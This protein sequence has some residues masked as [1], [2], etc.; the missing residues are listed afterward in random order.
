M[1]KAIIWI[2]LRNA[3]KGSC[4]A[5]ERSKTWRRNS[6]LGN[7]VRTISMINSLRQ[8]RSS[9]TSDSRRRPSIYSTRGCR[10]GSQILSSTSLP[11]PSI[12]RYSSRT[13]SE[14]KQMLIPRQDSQPPPFLEWDPLS[15]KM[16]RERSNSGVRALSQWQ[17]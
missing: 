1:A 3:K 2:Q 16:T 10:K 5:K 8:M 14:R 13:R 15:R 6:R 4:G 9:L 17:S 7:R 12:A 11:P